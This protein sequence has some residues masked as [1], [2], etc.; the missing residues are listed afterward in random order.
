MWYNA[1]ENRWYGGSDCEESDCE[2]SDCEESGFVMRIDSLLMTVLTESTKY[3]D[4]SLTEL[5]STLIQ[6]SVGKLLGGYNLPKVVKV[7]QV[8]E[9]YILHGIPRKQKNLF[10]IKC[11]DNIKVIVVICSGTAT[12]YHEQFLID[13]EGNFRYPNMTMW[14]I[15]GFF[16]T[17]SYW[18]T[19]QDDETENYYVSDA[20]VRKIKEKIIEHLPENYEHDS[21]TLRPYKFVDGN[22]T[23]IFTSDDKE[24]YLSVKKNGN[25]IT[26]SLDYYKT[27][28]VSN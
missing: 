28:V 17:L 2:E 27:L 26:M 3:K 11:E 9:N 16:C 20:Q 10:F 21:F 22:P 24:Y 13:D 15:V 23:M 12:L 25:D 4:G 18:W 7:T 1:S 14:D 8:E 19:G 5:L 6:E